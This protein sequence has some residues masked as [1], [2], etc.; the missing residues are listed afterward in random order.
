MPAEPGA[1]TQAVERAMSL[2][3]CF[4]DEHSELRISELCA[5]T[6]LGQSTV[7]R[8]VSSLDRMG[9]LVQDARTG[10]YCLGPTVVTLGTVALNSSPTYR[11]ARQIAQSLAHATELGANLAELRGDELFYLGNFEGVK[12]PKSFT[13]AGRTAPLHATGM[14]K[15]L[16]SARSPAY[17]R[18]YYAR[19]LG[20]A[21]TPHTITGPAAMDRALEEIRSRGYATE[22]EELA[23]GRACVAAPIRGR[24]GDVVAALS[25][26]GPLSE[27]DLPGRQREL[28]LMVVEAA[29]EVS[30]ALG[31][32]VVHTPQPRL[33]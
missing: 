30:I 12:S 26:S 13:M 20:P 6:G 7:S 32:T 33:S 10:L 31:F 28:A 29:D 27:L 15:T 9:F 22:I 25:V 23:F 2:L 24:S 1:G 16:L 17:V 11:A 4:T 3:A 5:R 8:M 18:D 21:Y 19:D 14:G